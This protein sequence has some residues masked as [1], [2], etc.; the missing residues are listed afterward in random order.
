MVI[1][2]EQSPP[3]LIKTEEVAD[4]KKQGINLTGALYRT[5]HYVVPCLE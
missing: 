2:N 5:F 4:G 3:A 1:I